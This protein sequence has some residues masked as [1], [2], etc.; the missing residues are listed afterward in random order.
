MAKLMRIEFP[1]AVYHITA[2]GNEIEKIFLN[3]SDWEIFLNT[4]RQAK[5]SLQ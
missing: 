1:G 4:L 5:N 2:R 3:D